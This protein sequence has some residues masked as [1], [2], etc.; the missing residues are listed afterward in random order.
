MVRAQKPGKP[1]SP[2]FGRFDRPDVWGYSVV[3]DVHF[4][5]VSMQNDSPE[6]PDDFGTIQS[7]VS[8]TNGLPDSVPI[9]PTPARLARRFDRRA[10][11]LPG[12]RM[13]FYECFWGY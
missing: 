12:V 9:C 5:Q 6:L 3:Q 11:I 13:T 2:P 10:K 1:G 7:M 8:P 4:A